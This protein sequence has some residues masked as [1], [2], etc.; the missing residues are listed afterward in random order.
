MPKK[1]LFSL[2]KEFMM[3]TAL[4]DVLLFAL[5]ARKLIAKLKFILSASVLIPTSDTPILFQFWSR[6]LVFILLALVLKL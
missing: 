2:G 5:A 6:F 3:R 4:L 1:A